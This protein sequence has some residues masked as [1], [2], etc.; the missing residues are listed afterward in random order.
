MTWKPDDEGADIT[1]PPIRFGHTAPGATGWWLTG[2]RNVIAREAIPMC[3]AI[4]GEKASPI[5]WTYCADTALTWVIQ[6]IIL[7]PETTDGEDHA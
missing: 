3:G 5:A 4:V 6:G 7:K 2:G 1:V